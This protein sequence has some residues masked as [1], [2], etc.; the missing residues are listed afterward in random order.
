MTTVE[1]IFC[2]WKK[3]KNGESPIMLRITKFRKTSYLA[4][5]KTCSSDHWD[6]DR[7]RISKTHP[8]YK[9]LK[10]LFD[11]RVK[12][13]EKSIIKYETENPN[14]SAKELRDRF[15][16]EQRK[17][18]SN[19]FA[20][21]DL[22]IARLVQSGR[23]GYADVFKSTKNSLK[24]FLTDQDARFADITP[25]TICQYENYLLTRQIKPNT[26]SV[27]MRTF[28]TLIN[29]ARNEQH[30][31]PDFDPFKGFS[32]AKY[33]NIK[34]RKRALT[35]ENIDMIADLSLKDIAPYVDARNIFIFSFYTRGMNFI[36]IAHLKWSDIQDGRLI[37]IRKKTKGLFNIKLL[38]PAIE[39]LKYYELITYHIGNKYIFP[40][41]DQRR[42][43]TPVSI[44][45]RIHKLLRK[46]NSDLNEISKIV[47]LSGPITTYVARHSYGNTMKQNGISATVIREQYGHAAEKTTQIYLD[48]LGNDMLDS[49][50]EDV[51][52][53]KQ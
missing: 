48:T 26:I 53:K 37:Y 31:N 14:V 8:N 43:K 45:N 28:K 23:I 42:H 10:A 16:R 35:K 30:V 17:H 7:N 46:T 36:D 24:A 39:I 25:A 5:G 3:Y 51:L 29:Y 41:L 34:T 1:I 21:F 15:T 44:D 4:V 20:Y 49:I 22:V 52:M 50:D 40:I 19:L 33:R 18:L 32:M 12:K 11:D 13:L 47:G 27:Y 9:E 38:P 2:R 6:F